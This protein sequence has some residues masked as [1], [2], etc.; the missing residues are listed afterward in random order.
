MLLLMVPIFFTFD[1][2]GFGIILLPKARILTFGAF[3]AFGALTT[4]H[5]ISYRVAYAPR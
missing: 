4:H 1:A 5:S 3:C 2:I